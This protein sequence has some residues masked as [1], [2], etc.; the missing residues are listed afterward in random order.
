MSSSAL[1]TESKRHAGHSQAGLIDR[2]A[3][4][5]LL[6][7]IQNL[8]D[9]YLQ[10]HDGN[11]VFT[12]G[13]PT[14]DLHVKLNV[15]HP[16]FYRRT[17]LGGSLG[18]S[19]SFLDGEWTCDDLTALLRL[20][21][22]NLELSDEMDRGLPRMAKWVATLAHKLRANTRRGAQRNIQ[23][24]YDL[25][26]DF[27]SLFL[28]ERMMYSCAY[29]ETPD[30]S[31]ETASTAKLETICRKLQLS[32]AD[33]VLEIGTGWGGFA[34]YAARHFGCRVTTTTIS[35]EQYDYAQQKINA[36][37]LSDRVE[38]L[39]KDYRDL[40]GRY[41]K[42]VSIEM[43][44]AVGHKFL[45][46][47]FGKCGELLSDDGLMLIQGITMPEQ[48]YRQYL[49]SVDFI[50]RFVFPGACLTS[51]T[52]MVDAAAKNTNLRV[53]HLE[54]WSAHYA[55]TLR[56]WRSRFFDKLDDV[57]QLGFPDRFLRLWNYYLCYCEAGFEERLTGLVQMMFAKP[58]YRG[59]S[60]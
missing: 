58:K 14:A 60:I 1:L 16:R 13:D 32:P 56:R 34:E 35:R 9:G 47:F 29:F 17:A 59:D 33:H 19:E 39:L 22:R 45:G 12:A 25:S 46:T 10:I 18:A 3:Q 49:R 37:G 50:Q 55:E 54:D 2:F 30:V 31:L 26:N 41:H 20:F 44:E 57:K 15:E 21:G 42:L 51:Q 27:F 28:D 36:A 24:H 48:R 4:R 40:S 7:G 23:D 38:I 5:C 53:T 8:R 43:I 11:R 52:A 6:R